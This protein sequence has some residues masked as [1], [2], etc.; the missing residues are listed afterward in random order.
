ML[1]I[2][3]LAA[4]TAYAEPDVKREASRLL[5]EILTQGRALGVVVVACVQDPRKDT[6][7]MRGLF[8]QTIAL[9]LRSAE[10]TRM[11][12]GDGTAA[13]APA[14]RVSPSAPGCGWV[15]DDD[16]T[17]DRVR[18]DHWPDPLV[19][20]VATR[21]PAGVLEDVLGAGTSQPQDA[22]SPQDDPQDAN[23]CG[24][25]SA[26]AGPRSGRTLRKPRSPRTRASVS[27]SSSS[28]SGPAPRGWVA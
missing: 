10:E 17:A 5:S 16:G 23:R 13:L 25:G 9:R 4:L 1:V 7:S 21:Y 15:I 3:E 18:A 12:L 20:Q 26:D 22:P 2:D 19:R 11:V 28:S 8:T 6:V 24:G 14:H 27:P